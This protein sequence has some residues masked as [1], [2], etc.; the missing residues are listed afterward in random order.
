MEEGL[1]EGRGGGVGKGE[2]GRAGG[3]AVSGHVPVWD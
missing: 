1:G 3:E 2:T